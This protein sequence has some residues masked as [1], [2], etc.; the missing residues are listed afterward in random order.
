ME[1]RKKKEEEIKPSAQKSNLMPK[2]GLL[3]TGA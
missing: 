3:L 2:Q 1:V